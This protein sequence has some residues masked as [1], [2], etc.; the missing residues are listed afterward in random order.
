MMQVV[1]GESAVIDHAC[2][3]R[4]YIHRDHIGMVKFSTRDDTEYKKVLHAIETVLEEHAR[5]KIDPA[6]GGK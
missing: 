2:E 6:E 1:D 5:D 4:G 3:Y